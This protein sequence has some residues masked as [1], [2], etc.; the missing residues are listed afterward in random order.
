LFVARGGI[1]GQADRLYRN[2]G[3]ELVVVTDG[4]IVTDNAG[5]FGSAWG[6]VDND[7][8]LDLVVANRDD[9]DV[10]YINE[11]GEF[12]PIS[13]GTTS[14][15]WS[16]AAAL[17][18]HDE[19]G[20]LDLFMT[21]GGY[22]TPSRNRHLVNTTD[23]THSDRHWV[24]LDLRGV[25]SDRFGLGARASVHATIGGVGRVLVREVVGRSGRMAQDGFRLHYGLAD[26][27]SI[28]SVVVTWPVTGRAVYADVAIDSI[29]TI[30]EQG[31]VIAQPA[32]TRTMLALRASPNPSAGGITFLASGLESGPLLLT[33]FDTLGR[34]VAT[35]ETLAAG[36]TATVEWP[37]SDG[38][39]S[40][41]YFARVENGSRRVS[42]LVV[43][44]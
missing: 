21:H 14:D 34:R 26:A 9:P 31:T 6:D 2:E 24:Q 20:D 40:G 23:S 37:E 44:R 42:T 16:I 7:G 19:D 29:H 10:L 28:D 25:L 13:F 18:D 33:L 15:G 38:L 12:E 5:T 22:A 32:P 30:E 27:T 1:T 41:R 36:P 17:V 39:R 11:E 35:I 4:P 43:V 8:D 3:G